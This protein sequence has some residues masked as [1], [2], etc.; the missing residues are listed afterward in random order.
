MSTALFFAAAQHEMVPE[1]EFACQ[2]SQRS[3]TD[4][5]RAQ[6]TQI[7]F[8]RFRTKPVYRL[9]DNKVED[10]IAEE[11]QALVTLPAGAAMSQR[12]PEQSGFGKLVVQ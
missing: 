3:V 6:A 11:L 9:G 7:T 4:E 1:S 10:R 5:M 8:A 2:F 12:L